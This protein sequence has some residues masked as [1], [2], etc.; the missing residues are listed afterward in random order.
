MAKLHVP[1]TTWDRIMTFLAQQNPD[2]MICLAAIVGTVLGVSVIVL[3]AN[4]REDLA[5][6][7]RG[8]RVRYPSR[9][10]YT[11]E[12]LIDHSAVQELHRWRQ[13]LD[14]VTAMIVP[15]G[16]RRFEFRRYSAGGAIRVSVPGNEDWEREVPAWAHGRRSEI[17]ARIEERLGPLGIHLD[18]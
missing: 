18:S 5:F 9:E 8:Y 15:R 17:V 7:R 14:A 11:Y 1:M 6:Q 16:R 12:E 10:K 3:M 13:I 4:I 2:L